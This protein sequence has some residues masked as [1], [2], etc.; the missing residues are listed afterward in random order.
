MKDSSNSVNYQIAII[1]LFFKFS[2]SMLR[3]PQ[4]SLP[5]GSV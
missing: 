5:P 2:P 3:K 4:R 1:H